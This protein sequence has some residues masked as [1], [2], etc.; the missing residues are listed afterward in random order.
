MGH[1][2]IARLQALGSTKIQNYCYQDQWAMI[3]IKGDSAALR[4]SL[5]TGGNAP[6]EAMLTLKSEPPTIAPISDQ[7]TTA[8]SVV[9]QHRR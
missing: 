3:T 7:T 1:G 5:P 8:G 2:A 4:E 9:D 6:A